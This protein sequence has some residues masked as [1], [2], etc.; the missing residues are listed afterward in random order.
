[1]YIVI[2]RP[3]PRAG[4]TRFSGTRKSVLLKA[5]SGERCVPYNFGLLVMLGG[6]HVHFI[7]Y[8]TVHQ[9]KCIM[10]K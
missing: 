6:A 3:D 7:V 4:K 10:E 1:M 8:L 9:M 2:F 5:S